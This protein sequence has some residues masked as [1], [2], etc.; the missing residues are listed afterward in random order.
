MYRTRCAF[1]FM[2]AIMSLACGVAV[3]S[4]GW[5]QS[6]VP[7][8][9]VYGEPVLLP[10]VASDTWPT[11]SPD[12]SQIAF[13]STPGPDPT[14]L[15]GVVPSDIYVMN[16][17]G[18]NPIKTN[19]FDGIGGSGNLAWSLDSSKIAFTC[20]DPTAP[21]LYNRAS[22]WE[23]FVM[24]ADGTSRIR[25][26][27]NSVQDSHPTWSPDGSKIAFQSSRGR[28]P[29]TDIYVM[30]ADGANPVRLTEIPEYDSAFSPL[31]LPGGFKIAFLL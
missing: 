8:V 14:T 20:I 30:N 1:S 12:G 25:L 7:E 17:D 18:T 6:E 31:W 26:T 22:I 9:V 13:S 11:Y 24:N 28:D 3:P 4:L 23:I 27:H 21:G 19:Q 10:G 16:A 2:L 15:G 5:A 29:R